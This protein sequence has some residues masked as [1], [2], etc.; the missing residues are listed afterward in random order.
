MTVYFNDVLLALP[1]NELKDLEV[2]MP[3]SRTTSWR[4]MH[5]LGARREAMKKCYYTDRH[6]DADV[7]KYREWYG[8]SMNQL[9][10]RM[11][12]FI[13]ITLHEQMFFEQC[14]L[15]F[16][17]GKLLPNGQ[18][19][20]HMD[21]LSAFDDEVKYKRVLHPDWTSLAAIEG[22]PDWYRTKPPLSEW[23]CSENHK[24]NLCLCHTGG[25]VHWGQYESVFTSK[26][27]PKKCWVIN[28]I[29]PM[30][31]KSEGG[32]VMVSAYTCE[33]LGFGAFGRTPDDLNRYK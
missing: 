25:L 24:Y 7:K 4:W 15:N 2:E 22:Q 17:S 5:A 14:C 26:S 31:P 6:E 19:I 13:I 21:G 27:L 33:E 16:P 20:H 18:V 28:G 29:A 3:V 10:K 11:Y 12:H 32:G 8:N 23:R 1:S 9:E 30:H